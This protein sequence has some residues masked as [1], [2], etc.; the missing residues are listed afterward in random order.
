MN[1]TNMVDYYNDI[2]ES[3]MLDDD[4]QLNYSNEIQSQQEQEEN[5][6]L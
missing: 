4:S 5:E 2:V 3:F 6:N 1:E